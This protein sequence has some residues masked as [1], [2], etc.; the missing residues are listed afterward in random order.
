MLRSG[1]QSMLRRFG[2]ELRAL[3][4]DTRL[5]QDPVRDAARLVTERTR[6][7]ILDAGANI[8]QTVENFRCH[9]TQPVLHSFEPTPDVFPELQRN[10]GH[11]PDVYLN[12]VALGA[13]PGRTPLFRH[14]VGS[15]MNSLL[16][17]GT[18]CLG[19]G[20]LSGECEV[21][22]TTIDQYCESMGIDSI[23]ILK[24]DVQGM[25]FDVVK[26]AA[27]LIESGAVQLVLMEVIFG[28]MYKGI[29]RFDEIFGWMTDRG[30]R[31]VSFYPFSY[32][33]NRASWADALFIQPDFHRPASPSID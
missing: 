20:K 28:D 2:Y 5:G 1:I 10:V 11:L 13:A 16:E 25:D 30:F 17:A 26:G 4:P 15:P 29:P 24:T 21:V 3:T 8:G 23:D 22:V 31:L 6:P 33:N 7:V 27:K 18:E 32:A 12:N 9:F 19:G 14:E